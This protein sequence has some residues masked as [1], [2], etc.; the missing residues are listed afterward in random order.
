MVSLITLPL[1]RQCGQFASH[2]SPMIK[3][4][5]FIESKKNGDVVLS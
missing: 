3:R 5:I 4:N 1:L 2:S